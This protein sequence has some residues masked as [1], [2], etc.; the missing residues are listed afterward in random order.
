[1]V[2]DNELNQDM[3]VM[4]PNPGKKQHNGKN[5]VGNIVKAQTSLCI[6]WF[7]IGLHNT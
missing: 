1:M 5:T 7:I 6:R 3:V 2:Y 4:K